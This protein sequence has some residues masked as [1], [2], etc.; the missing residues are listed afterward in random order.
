MSENLAKKKRIRAGHRASATRM[1]RQSDELLAVAPPDT[2]KLSQLK[3]S[4]EEKLGTLKQL[5]GEI[6]ELTDEEHLIEE[7]EQAD[8]FKEGI[9]AAMV[10]I[11]KQ[12]AAPP[13]APETPVTEPETAR[14]APTPRGNR[15]KLPKLTLRAFNGDITT[16]T[17]FW[18]SYESAI[19]INTELSDIDKFNYLRSLLERTALEAVSGLTLTS[20]NYHEAVS[21]LKKRFG[22]KHQIISKHMDI[23]LNVEPVTS[24]HN[25]KSLR[26]LYDLVESHIR[27]LKSLGVSSDSYGSLLS[28][29]LLNKLPQELRLIVSRKVTDADW[30]LDAL[31]KVM[32]EEVEARERTQTSSAQQQSRRGS[33]RGVHTAAALVTGTNSTNPSCCYCQQAHSSNNCKTVIQTEARKIILRKSGRC[34][35][36]LRKGHISRNCRSTSKCSKCSGRHHTSICERDCIRESTQQPP[37]ASTSL[38]AQSNQPQDATATSQAQRSSLNPHA[39][40]YTTTPTT[41]S[42]YVNANK[43]VMLQ[44]AQ[45]HI[46]NPHQ[47]QLTSEVRIILDSGSQ[48]SYITSR[49]KDA[50]SL[51][52]EGKQ[53]LSVITF[54][55]TKG[56]PK[57]CEVVQVGMRT[58]DGSDQELTLFTVPLICEPLSAQPISLCSEKYSHLSQLDLADLSN[59]ESQL[60]VDVLIGSDHYWDLVT[61]ETIRGRSGPVA[62]NTK[63]GWVLSGPAQG[64][65]LDQTSVNLITTHALRI[66]SQECD[67]TRLDDRLRSFWELESLG[68]QSPDKSVSEEFS[69]SIG[70]SGGRYEVSLPWKDFHD[71]LPD[72][73]QLSLRR[74]RGL[75]RRLQQDPT[76]LHDYDA[77]I[78]DQIKKGIVE[79]VEDT[80]RPTIGKVHYLP[81]HGVIRHDKKTT[82]LRIVYDA[83]ARSGGPSLNDCLYTGPKFDQKILDILLRFRSYRVALTADIE[84]AFLMISMASCDR[85]V[86]RFLWVKDITQD[87]PDVVILRFT[88][89][90]FGVSSSPFLLNATIRHHIE[91][92]SSSHP[93][94]AQSL[95]QSIYVDDIVYGADSEEHAYD[96]YGESKKI[97]KEGGF[98]L[99]KFTTNSQQLQERIDQAEKKQG[100]GVTE[101]TMNHDE[102]YAKGTLGNTQLIFPGEDRILGVRWDATS[103]QLI[104]NFED[105]A[106]SAVEPNPTKRHVVTIIGK[107][108]DPLGFMSPIIIRFKI[109]FQELC[110]PKLDWDEPLSGKLLK[111]WHSLVADL[112]E[113]QP[114]SVP[115]SYLANI[116]QAVDTYSLCGFCDASVN[117][118]AAVVYLV[119]KTSTGH[120]VRFVV[121]KTRVAPVKTQTIP[122]LELLSALLL[123]RLMV[124]V[125]QGLESELPLTQPRCFT[126]SKVA[127]FWIQG[128]GKE[129]KPFVQN[130]VNEIRRL[131]PM[132]CWQHCSG[133]NNPADIPSR[134]LTPLEL[135]VNVLWRKGP[136][137]LSRDEA[138]EEDQDFPMPEDCVPEMR[139]NPNRNSAHG[140][141]TTEP[142]TGLECIMRC[143]DY[144]TLSRLLRVT[145]QLLR[146]VKLFK[147]KNSSVE[148]TSALSAKEVAEAKKL[149][150]IQSQLLLTQDNKF[151]TWK[152]QFGLF[153]DATG[154]WRCGGRLSNA[155]VPYSTKHPVLLHKDHTLAS[156]I[157]K[158]AHARVQHNGVKE[159]L[160]EI[161]SKYWIIKGRSLVKKAV[162]QCVLCRK[163]EGVPY[164]AP[165]PPPLP[166][167]RVKEEPPFSY[168]GVDFA[169]PLYIKTSDVT[170]SNKVWICLYT[171]CVTR[172]VHLEIVPD[173]STQT[174]IRS[175]KRF[176]ARRGLP[177]K[178]ISDNGKTFKAAAKVVKA[179]INDKNVQQHLSGIGV[180]WVFNI[181][182]AP[183]WGGIF[184]R[185]I[186]S[187]KRCLR[188]MIARAKFS[189]DELLTAITE[190]EMIINS[191][192]LSYVSPDDLEEPLT[193]SHLLVG[194]RLLS[195]PDNLCYCRDVDD[196]DFEVNPSYLNK[197]LKYLNNILNQFWRRW[198]T[199]YLLDLRESHRYGKGVQVDAPI[200][201]G[202]IVL[203]H[204]EDQPRAFWKVA[205]VEDIIKGRDGRIRGATVRL[206]VKG[207]RSILLRRPLQ[208]LYPLEVNSQA[209]VNDPVNRTEVSDGTTG[210]KVGVHAAPT[211]R[212]SQRAAAKQADSRRKACMF[213]LND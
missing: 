111:K 193:P 154:I 114:I 34:F 173:M 118:Y 48:R 135:S 28:S 166:I 113:S 87:Q 39:A 184:E 108:Y 50:L 188:K 94:S 157:V 43:T 182:K 51:L 54:G 25:L 146:S 213:E 192:P 127:L 129:W 21:I 2:V 62:I 69:N 141:L 58:K 128:H 152:K 71:P 84:K 203:V 121:S 33:D 24:V 29:V 169:G 196:D 125:A 76:L 6:V 107:F 99:R 65:E 38:V 40:I 35:T 176:A 1:L 145:A 95:L 212:Q 3:L 175:L 101:S 112:Q 119:I 68:I 83:S 106:Q 61:G 46:F 19:H 23:L 15:V 27:S 162:H 198:R 116:H 138:D 142:S 161:R 9:F 189:Y 143:E 131:T 150:I 100:V 136:D 164:R 14:T 41:T 52:S 190:V 67:M 155:D 96:L 153:L 183:W 171:C 37:S 16:W 102:T 86:L 17:T 211:L 77:I 134:G 26:H 82:K 47:P 148:N 93:K 20:A 202:D 74:L 194:R 56:D 178:F 72:N 115:R 89:V 98:N 13:T 160:T 45:A 191:R 80:E 204:S 97:L 110:G 57:S 140:L 81:H 79:V 85:D 30:S 186:R 137:W 90:M 181:E 59:S 53:Q 180:E 170:R 10:R 60:E 4:L 44:T 91:K 167:F 207:S 208:L 172:A 144:S 73:Y 104:F 205:K 187:T 7:I 195:L 122:R 168:T 165:P 78:Q 132:E 66:D 201:I 120:S 210:D 11:E 147:R 31:M 88:R 124:T 103:D 163:L 185:L 209:S 49:V 200:T 92:F 199:E 70:F 177:H 123:A 130:R 64:A 156:L 109:F 206:P 117:A 36:C 139:A 197:R 179:V 149:W 42:L 8:G 32:E 159:T 174:F 5:D 63:V 158:S 126:D 151:N 22:N 75:L 55:S 133:K 18:D 105:V 12:C